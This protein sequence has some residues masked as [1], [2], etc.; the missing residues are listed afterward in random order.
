M[1][2]HLCGSAVGYADAADGPAAVAD[3]GVVCGDCADERGIGPS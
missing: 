3:A 1:Y 2:C